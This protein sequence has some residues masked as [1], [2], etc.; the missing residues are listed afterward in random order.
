MFNLKTNT[1][2]Q[3]LA[4]C[5]YLNN[6]IITSVSTTVDNRKRNVYKAACDIGS[7]II[8]LLEVYGIYISFLL[9]LDIYAQILK[10]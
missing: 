2:I 6:Q 9:P 8:N 1:T 10:I 5:V 7:N 4:F 3:S